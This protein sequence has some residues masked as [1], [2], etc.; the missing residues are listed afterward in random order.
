MTDSTGRITPGDLSRVRKRHPHIPQDALFDDLPERV[1]KAS[2]ERP[3][4]QRSIAWAPCPECK[5]K[6]IGLLAVTAD[7]FQFRPHNRKVGRV[8]IPCSGSGQMYD[9]TR[10]DSPKAVF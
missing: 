6:L 10:F 4:T 7:T 1:A 9:G 2:E 5:S 3:R 8:T